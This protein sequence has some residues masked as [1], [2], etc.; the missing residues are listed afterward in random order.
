MNIYLL[1]KRNNYYLQDFLNIFFIILLV[2]IEIC[3]TKI[4]AIF[5]M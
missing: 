5:F 1:V 3:L 2:Y 4:L